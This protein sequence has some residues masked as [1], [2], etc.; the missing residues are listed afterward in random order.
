MSKASAAAMDYQ[1]QPDNRKLGHIPGTKGIPVLGVLL[2]FKRDAFGFA[3]KQYDKFGPIS[4]INMGPLPGVMALGPDMAQALLLDSD[5]N[6]S[7]AMG[8]DYAL[9]TFFGDNL[10][11]R[12]FDDHRFQRRIM[13][14]SF[15]NAAMKSYVDT[16]NPILEKGMAQWDFSGDFRFYTNI[17]ELLLKMA[18]KIFYGVEEDGEGAH[19][20]SE[21][22]IDITI[23][24]EGVIRIDRPPFDYHRGKNGQRFMTD[25][26]KRLIPERREGDGQ[27]MLSHMC[28]ETKPDGSYFSDDEIVDH[29]SFLLFAAH[30]TTTST[31]THLMYYLAKL[32][33]WQERLREEGKALG[34]DALS[35][36]DLERVEWLDHAFHESQRLHPS[37]NLMMRR[38]VRDCELAGHHIPAH[39][40]IFQVPIFTNRMEEYWTRP[41]EF[42]PD[43]FVGDRMEQKG[44]PFC[45]MP[46]GGGAHKCI[47]MH[48]ASMQSKLFVHQFLQKFDFRLP[49]GHK[50]EFDYVPLPKLKDKL[51]LLV[52]RR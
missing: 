5:K 17:K 37:V 16:M 26:I 11:C 14:T 42:E 28:K 31:L 19:L 38:S 44:H 22:F 3:R 39:T 40:Q 21:A 32:P 45:Y 34:V 15:K 43:R 2:P 49:E 9:R 52:T 25:Y 46:F 20:L 48:F 41:H 47:G 13:Q 6:F 18:C 1:Q 50:A 4:R 8:Y 36:E 12:D 51:P 29:A 27:D 30:D 24:Q 23:G 33:E 10:L 35:Y 7:S